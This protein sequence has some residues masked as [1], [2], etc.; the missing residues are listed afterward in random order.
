MDTIQNTLSLFL[1]TKENVLRDRWQASVGQL[2]KRLE[3]LS[4]NEGVFREVRGLLLDLVSIVERSGSV[5][6]AVDAEF[7]QILSHLKA[8]QADHQLSSTD[9]VFLLFSMRDTV[10]EAVREIV[11]LGPQGQHE[12]SVHFQAVSQVSMLLNRLGLV[13]FEGAMR[14]REDGGAQDVLAIEYALLYERARQMA[15]TD[16]LTGLYN[17]GYFLERLKEERLR[18]ERYHRLLSL[19]ILDIDHFKKYNDSNGHPAGNEVLKKIATILKQEAREVDIVARYGGEEMVVVLPETSRKRATELAERIRQR[20]NE[21]M[22]D[23]MQSQPLGKMTVSA[24][25]ATFP[26]DASNEE[27]LVKKA[28]SSLYLAKSQGR[29]R[30]VAFEPP[31][32]VTIAYR[33]QRELQKVSLVGDF[34][35]WD[36]DVDFMT[37]QEDGSFRFVISLNPGIYH[38]KFVLNDLEWIPDPSSPEHVH[39][40]LGGDN[41]ILRVN[42]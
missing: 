23:R 25:V 31:I 11:D 20:I 38:Y 15:I 22:F 8:L 36:K 37:R 28:D 26:V 29:N 33:P 40:G 35:N 32:K 39:D 42:A 41:S 16:R 34:N 27:D 9:M 3:G 1:Q 12:I 30:I 14:L 24:G 10:R 4:G 2:S 5:E 18:A 13:F 21:T 6:Q 19:V 7:K 17:F